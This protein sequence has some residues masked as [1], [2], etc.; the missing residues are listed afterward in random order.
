LG[1][2]AI[3]PDGRQFAYSIPEGDSYSIRVGDAGAAPTDAHVLCKACGRLLQ[4]SADGRFLFYQPEANP[5]VQT[6][7]KLTVRL[8]ELTSGKDG[9]WLEHASDSIH[10][11]GAF[12]DDSRWVVIE[13]LP[14]E[15]NGSGP[16]YVV[17]WREK[18]VPPSEWIK[19]PLSATYNLVGAR[20]RNFFYFF[21][22]PKLMAI[23]F[24][25]HTGR[26]NEP[27]EIRL[28]TSSLVMFKSNDDWRV[29]GPGLAFSRYARRSSVWLMKLPQ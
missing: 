29:R 17:P 27:H 21:D 26:F 1:R 20:T 6:K 28:L 13:L 24:D 22:G 5:K 2:L 8:L 16:T 18:A 19:V 14:P 23:R 4:F 15:S 25:S 7:R 12:G 10:V 3:S 11:R 9:P